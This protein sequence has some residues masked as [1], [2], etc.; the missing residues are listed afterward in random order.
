MEV[1]CPV[2][3]G[4]SADELE[5]CSPQLL[6]AGRVVHCRHSASSPQSIPTMAGRTMPF[7]CSRVCDAL[8][9]M[10]RCRV[11][12]LSSGRLSNTLPV[13]WQ[14]ALM[15][16]PLCRFLALHGCMRLQATTRARH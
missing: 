14:V 16:Q 6:C 2:D 4:R 7:L 12:S 11:H 5:S 1:A 3:Q 9:F 10:R 13:L 15:R 8:R